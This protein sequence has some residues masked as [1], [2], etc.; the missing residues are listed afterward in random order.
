[1]KNDTVSRHE[2]TEA[3]ARFCVLLIA[4]ATSSHLP[5]GTLPAPASG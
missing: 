2:A 5:E 3:I 4:V 1:M